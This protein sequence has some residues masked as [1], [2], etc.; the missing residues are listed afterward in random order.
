[1]KSLARAA[2][3]V[4]PLAPL[5]AMLAG[6]AVAAAAWAAPIDLHDYWDQR[7]STCHG[8]SAEFARRW[9]TVEQGR[10]QGN[11]HRDDLA[12]FLRNHYLADDLVVPVMQMLAAQADQGSVFRDRCARCHGTAAEFAR[13]SLEWRDGALYGRSGGKTVGDALKSHGGLSPAENAQMLDTLTRVR[14]EVAPQP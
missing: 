7:C 5:A 11:H 10:L 4:L 8:H 1:M 13:R 9:L 14:R 2:R 3:R 6:A 12:R